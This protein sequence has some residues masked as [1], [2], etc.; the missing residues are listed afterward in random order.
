MFNNGVSCIKS[1]LGNI[2]HGSAG[3]V[4]GLLCKKENQGGIFYAANEY[5]TFARTRSNFSQTKTTDLALP[6]FHELSS[7]TV[8]KLSVLLGNM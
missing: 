3:V 6:D 2:D 5:P 7:E 8:T 1:C 4:E